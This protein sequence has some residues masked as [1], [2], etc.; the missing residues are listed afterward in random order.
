[1]I[2]IL[3][4]SVGSLVGQN[5]LDALENRRKHL[6]IIGLNS[7]AESQRMYRCDKA[8]L[9]QPTSS[10]EFADTYQS[11]MQK[12]NPD[13]VLAGRDQ[14]VVFLAN[15]KKRAMGS[16]ELIPVGE[17]YLAEM[18]LDKFKTHQFAEQ[19]QLPY[20]ATFM[21]RN[22]LDTDGLQAFIA[23]HG[24]PLLVKPRK[25]FGSIN[26]FV[27]TN[28]Q[29]VDMCIKDGDEVM[30]QE[31][32]SPAEGLDLF[33]AQLK[34]GIP[35]SFQI[36]NHE[37]MVS[38]A[39]IS[40]NGT[41]LDYIST[42]QTLVMG[43]TE[44]ARVYNDPDL[45]RMIEL[46]A[47]TLAEKGWWGF[48]NLQSRRDKSGIWKVFELN[49]RLSGA[50]STRLNL[51]LDELGLLLNDEKPEWN[52]PLEIDP[53]RKQNHVFKYLTD[54]CVSDSDMEQFRT[55]GYWINNE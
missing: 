45:N 2:K 11:I 37:H 32:L 25:G 22:S 24:F 20:A 39:V 30:F 41:L 44:Y 38:Q 46:Y 14:D 10:P 50:T 33:V 12:E 16:K 29:H 15:Y 42:K 18:M 28:Q 23:T 47:K 5:I 21:Y 53:S 54:H 40:R 17:P 4:T 36:P 31:Y 35:L 52:F 3:I 51:G 34:K 1:M 43:R 13:L 9:V 27:V 8:Y 6:T 26:V 48:L 19:H 49:P 7:I 55:R